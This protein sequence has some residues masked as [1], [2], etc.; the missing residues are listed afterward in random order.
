MKWMFDMYAHKFDVGTRVRYRDPR[1]DQATTSD[2]IVS[3][4]LSADD[5]GYRYRIDE[6]GGQRRIVHESE[7]AQKPL[8][9]DL[10]QVR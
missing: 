8:T 3:R 2:L 7:I 4:Q 6:P 1:S 5:K 9:R 10:A